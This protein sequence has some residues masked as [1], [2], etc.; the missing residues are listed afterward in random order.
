MLACTVELPHAAAQQTAPAVTVGIGIGIIQGS[1]S[2]QQSTA[3]A[4]ASITII[5][6][7]GRIVAEAASDMEGR[8]RVANLTAGTYRVMAALAGFETTT[9]SVLVSHEGP[10]IITLDL[11]IAR[12]ADTIDVVGETTAVSSGQTLAPVEAIASRELDQFVPGQ[13]LQGA[14]RMLSTVIP[15]SGGVSIKGGRPGQ[16]GMQLGTTTLIDPASGVAQVPLPDGAIESVTVLPNPYAVEYGRF[17][18]GLVV[19]QSRRAR[20]EWKLRANRF[21]PSLRSTNDGGLRID[22]F[23]PRAEMEG[24]LVKDRVYLA[25]SV[26]VRYSIGDVSS[27]AETEQRVT[28]AL[29]S[30]S[31]VDASLSPKHL[32][33][34]TLGLFPNATD[35]ATVGTFTPPE[36]S[37]NLR[38]LGTQASLTERA[39][40]TNRTV[41]E[42]TFQWFQSRTDVDPQGTAPMELQ[43]DVTLGNFFNRQH[44]ATSS[45]Q[46]VHVVTANRE[47]VGGS[48]LFKVGVDLL[49]TQY[50]GTS[51]SQTVLIER[52]DGTVVRRLDFPGNNVSSVGNV[53][54][55][56][57]ISGTEAAVF[58]QDRLQPHPRWYVEAGLRV[59]RD[60]VLRRANVSPRVGTAVLLTESGSAVLRGGW[61]LFVERTPSMAG[62]FRSF[63]S[64]VDTRFTLD[65]PA[66]PG[67]AVTQS[68][69]PALETP[70]SRTWDAG[71]DYRWNERWMF[72]VGMLNREGRHELIVTPLVSGSLVSRQLSSDGRSSYRDVEIGAHYTRGA[73]VDVDATYTRS[74]SE[75][76]LNTLTTACS[77]RSS[78]RT[79]M[80]RSLP[81]CPIVCSCAA[82]WF[83]ERSGCCSASWTGARAC[84][85]PS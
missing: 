31:R 71:F 82:A 13:G 76:D 44:R 22:G 49:H 85:T 58:A 23:S 77:R 67:V 24:P 45:Y 30:F 14:I 1:I 74:R 47:G 72:H 26:Q 32:V 64:A 55:V 16:A 52:A 69:A 36:A 80:R 21:G 46:V 12:F 29:S 33:I 70:A 2:T 5:D 20:D 8:F 25:Q 59:D 54:S 34:G 38:M 51:Q 35:F 39:L 40:W 79:R 83:Q 9:Q 84:R 43:P 3:L 6:A 42:T 60:G 53:G 61:G 15:V 48:H 57:A 27:R 81:T 78:A 50:D 62:V 28:K 10:A 4:G 68:V 7:T 65:A 17:S 41:S 73:L 63:E 75:G 56:Q 18:S 37:V 11:P 19:I 66:A